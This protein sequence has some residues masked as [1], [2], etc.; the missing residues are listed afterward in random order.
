[1]PKLIFDKGT[2]NIQW[3][4]DSLFNKDCWEKWLLTCRKLI[5]DPCLP[6]Y[7]GINSKL[8]KNLNFRPKTLKL[9]KKRA[10]NSLVAIGIGKNSSIG[11]H[12]SATKRKD[13]HMELHEVKKLCTTKEMVPKLKRPPTK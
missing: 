5:L 8:I 13:R 11:P 1:V 2:K 10:G 4:I 7:T 9:V 6:P 3:K 12:S